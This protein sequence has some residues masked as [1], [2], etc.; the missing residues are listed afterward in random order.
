MYDPQ[1]AV[2]LPQPFRI[3][4]PLAQLNPRK[5]ICEF[6]DSVY[7]RHWTQDTK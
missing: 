4:S 2:Y 1:D 5:V 7:E 3:P 6:M